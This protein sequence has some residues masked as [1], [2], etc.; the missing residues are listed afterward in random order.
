MITKQT[1]LN[2]TDGS[3][4]NGKVVIR[5]KK[6]K[7]RNTLIDSAKSMPMISREHF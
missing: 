4:S 1:T 5:L 7:S 3:P 2:L 6:E